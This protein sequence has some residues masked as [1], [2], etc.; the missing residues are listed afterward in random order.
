MV[1]AAAYTTL[2]EALKAEGKFREGS[3]VAEE[4]LGAVKSNWILY[5]FDWHNG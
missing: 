2:L 5:D 1:A 3:R 4:M